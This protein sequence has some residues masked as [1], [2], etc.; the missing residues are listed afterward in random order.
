[1]DRWLYQGLAEPPAAAVLAEVITLDKWFRQA[2][3][4][5]RPPVP[6]PESFIVEPIDPSLYPIPGDGAWLQPIGQPVLPR[7][8]VQPPGGVYVAAPS[9]FVVETVTL[10][11]WFQRASEPVRTVPP[12]PHGGCTH[13]G[14]PDDFADLGAPTIPG[15]EYTVPPGRMHYTVP[16]G[17]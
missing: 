9:T 17:E 3:E 10:D 15:P 13:Q 12:R 14:D 2:T 16:S 6:C 8:T 4:P 11:K 7:R 1:M 5:V